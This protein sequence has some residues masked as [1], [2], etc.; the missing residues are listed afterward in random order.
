MLYGVTIS[1]NVMF[2]AIA[3]GTPNSLILNVGSGVITVRAEKSV[4]FF[5]YL[6]PWSNK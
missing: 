1:G 4:R 3:I 5:R 6:Q 2:F